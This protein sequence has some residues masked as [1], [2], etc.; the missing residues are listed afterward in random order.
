[1]IIYYWK[2]SNFD[3]E[4]QHTDDDGWWGDVGSAWIRGR[5]IIIAPIRLDNLP[6]PTRT[7]RRY[8][9]FNKTMISNVKSSRNIFKRERFGGT[10]VDES[11][12]SSNNGT[13]YQNEDCT[14][15]QEHCN[16]KNILD[17]EEVPSSA[18]KQCVGFCPCRFIIFGVYY[19]YS[20]LNMFSGL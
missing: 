5:E 6:M 8:L 2:I 11:F 1:M 18:D 10:C 15:C 20:L 3:I 13:I 14:V 7:R 4:D 9:D 16:I 19:F 17:A 12:W